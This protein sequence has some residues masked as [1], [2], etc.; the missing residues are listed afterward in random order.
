L[1]GWSGDVIGEPDSSHRFWVAIAGAVIALVTVSARL[2]DAE[3]RPARPDIWSLKL[4]IPASA[5]PRDA[6]VDYACG[7]NGGPPQ[8]VL[9]GWSDYDKCP[10]EPTDC[11]NS[12][13]AM[14]TS[15]NIG[16]RRIAREH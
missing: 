16:Q 10:P 7:S 11:A 4:G 1:R 12:I 3:E 2:V 6:F 14:T 13:S 5:L 8:Q 15:S 9:T